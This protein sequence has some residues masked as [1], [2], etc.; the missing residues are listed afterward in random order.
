MLYYTVFYGRKIL[1]YRPRSEISQSI[2]RFK[3][4]LTSNPNINMTN[5]SLLQSLRGVTEK[6]KITVSML[7]YGTEK[8]GATYERARQWP[9]EIPCGGTRSLNAA[10][11]TYIRTISVVTWENIEK[12][13]RNLR[14]EV[15]RQVHVCS[16]TTINNRCRVRK[17][18]GFSLL[19]V[20]RFVD[21]V[22]ASRIATAAQ[23]R[24]YKILFISFKWGD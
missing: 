20:E 3:M 11:N 7:N 13:H 14:Q 17:L 16:I 18:F 24:I 1:L 23:W 15:Y 9:E 19:K 6:W 4:P 5:T 10:L 21:A 22:F 8:K 2:N 12:R